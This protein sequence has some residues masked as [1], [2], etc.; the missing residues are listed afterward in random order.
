MLP[1]ESIA[2]PAQEPGPPAILAVIV[3][4]KL[5]PALS[6]SYTTL[7]ESSAQAPHLDLTILL[8][9]NTP[10]EAQAPELPPPTLY[11]RCPANLG[12]ANAYN[13]AIELAQQ[14]GCT[15]LLTL[16][17]DSTLPADFLAAIGSIAAQVEATPA[18]AAIAPRLVS[19]STPLSPHFFRWGAVPQW[20]RQGW[21]G[22]PSKPV[23]A[24]NSGAMIRIDALEQ[25]G[26]YDP[27]FWLDASDAMLFR[28]LHQHGKRVFVAGSIVIG[29]Q[30]SMK[31]TSGRISPSRHRQ[32]LLAESAFWDAEMNPLAGLERTLRLFLRLW[33]HRVR[34]DPAALR[35]TGEFLALR[36]F[37]SRAYRLRLF[38]ESVTRQL[39][40]HLPDT[41]LPRRQPKISVCMAAYNGAPYIEQQ[42]QSIL[43]QL[44]AGDEVVI[45]DDASRD[46]T[47]ARIDALKAAALGG[48]CIR[49]IKHSVNQG[50][51]R[52]FEDALRNAT[53]DLLFLADDDDLWAPNKVESFLAAFAADEQVQLV[54]SAV[55][56]IDSEGR[57]F[58]DPRWD[59]G[60]R[61]RRGLFLNILQN[62]YQGSAMAFRA[63]LLRRV[64][65]FPHRSYLHDVW[66][67]TVNDRYRG[68]V[69]Y[70]PE[71]L[72][73]YRRHSANASRRLSRW[74]QLKQRLQLLWDHL[75]RSFGS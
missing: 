74:S 5:E 28:R 35:A 29:H 61:F 49:L 27:R 34:R 22:V 41:A 13:R 62:H 3:L 14:R 66:I 53:G 38:Q 31:A 64:L 43:P 12:L 73:K 65:P 57:P 63:S 20:F 10:G 59:R 42:L 58:H 37:R 48:P 69:I 54:T 44:R 11:L 21:S 70:L 72:L 32:M 55:A 9:D 60:G 25:V 7:L 68:G 18:I 1:A 26:G 71:P 56:L 67:G 51:V 36:L 40:S 19:G 17:Q 52:T 33:R 15:W 8:V 75:A 23:F 24:F 30:F 16:D 6:S 4:Y 46:E 50:V 47:R 45:V 2:E 39:G